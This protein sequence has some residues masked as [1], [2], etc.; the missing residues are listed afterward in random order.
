MATTTAILRRG[1]SLGGYQIDDLIAVGGT[2]MVYRAQQVSLGRSIALKVLSPQLSRDESFRER[3]RHEG[4]L[5][6]GLDHPNVVT[7]YDSGEADGLLY[8]AMRLVDGTTLAERLRGSSLSAEETTSILGP[9]AGALDA[10]HAIGLVHRDVQPQN[11]LLDSRGHPYLTDFGVAA[12]NGPALPLTGSDG[13]AGSVD[14]CAPEQIAGELPRATADVYSLTAVLY[15]CLTG[16]VPY[17]RDTDDD[18]M[19][20]HL[21]ERPPRLSSLSSVAAELNRVIAREWRSDLAVAT[22]RPAN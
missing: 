18:V 16:E 6:A 7:I 20:A 5:L 15:E 19:R 8:I 14:Y 3:F 17:P 13:F 2:V 10:A 1:G 21:H 11:I 4:R 22:P 9:I 12:A